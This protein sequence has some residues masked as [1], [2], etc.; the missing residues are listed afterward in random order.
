MKKFVLEKFVFSFNNIDS[1][2]TEHTM[3]RI[4][5]QSGVKKYKCIQHYVGSVPYT[6]FHVLGYSET[7]DFRHFKDDKN[8]TY[9][10]Y[11]TLE[12][13]IADKFDIFL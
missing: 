1:D 9:S 12:E 7:V 4:F 13:L 5:E 3:Y 2:G 11:D 8:Y 10:D 6:S